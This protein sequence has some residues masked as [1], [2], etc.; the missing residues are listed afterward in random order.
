MLLENIKISSTQIA[1]ITKSILPLLCL[2]DLIYTH[3][4]LFHSTESEYIALSGACQE[5]VWLRRLLADIGLEQKGPSTIYEDN[6]GAIELTK[7]PRFHNR[8]KH[9]DVSFHYI[10]EQVNL[11]TVSVKYCPTNV[12]LADIITK[13]LSRN[14][15]ETFRDNLRVKKTD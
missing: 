2:I 6:Q 11:K 13:G 1:R 3:A 5:A 15:F 12:M 10:R 14:A 4:S 8:T 7:N 9:I